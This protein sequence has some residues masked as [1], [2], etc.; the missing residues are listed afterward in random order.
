M[1]CT[2]SSI[3]LL[4]AI[5]AA[6]VIA[7][8]PNIHAQD[9]FKV[10][11]PFTWAGLPSG[12]L[13][14]DSK[15]DLYGTTEHGG[16]K[17]ER[18]CLSGCG[19]VYELVPGIDG[20][21]SVDVLHIFTDGDGYDPRGGMIFDKAG[22]LYGTASA[23]VFKLA[24]NAGG[25]WT[26]SVLY[27]GGCR[28]GL[29][30]DSAGNLYGSGCENI[31]K[32]TPS[33][34]GSWTETTLYTFSLD[35]VNG[36]AP[37]G[38]LIFDKA[39]NLYGMT[40]SGGDL[41]A[42]NEGCGVVFRLSPGPGESWTET[43]LYTF[44]CGADGGGAGGAYPGAG[45]VM[46]I[47]G[48]LYGTTTSGGDPHCG[49][50]GAGCGVAFELSP[51]SGTT[52][53]ETVLHTFTGLG[54]GGQPEVGLILDASGN[55]YGTTEAGGDTNFGVVYELSKSSS[56]SWTESVL[57][58]FLGYGKGTFAPVIFDSSGN[59]YGTAYEGGP[60]NGGLVFEI[61]P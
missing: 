7:Q 35:S 26:Y 1:Q 11:H 50:A 51:G 38:G 56:G 44:V 19:I 22:N 27:N 2:R 47:A 61:T 6:L 12:S 37:N 42:G 34:D 53:T 29:A 60:D 14:L 31:F 55:L 30:F 13:T 48:N 17:D 33:T 57:H 4:G 16:L 36:S 21:W 5:L 46:D 45:V 20:A 39:G 40:A 41:S 18:N 43:V 25:E 58:A 15:G 49:Y 8:T 10:L 3:L 59:L 9:T 24:P 28:S 52:W 32:L 54:D 23:I